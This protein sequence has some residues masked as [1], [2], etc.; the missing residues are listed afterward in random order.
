[1]KYAPILIFTYRRKVDKLIES[2]LKNKLVDEYELFIFSDG[3]KNNLDKEDV[4]EVRKSL[5]TISGFKSIQIY[6]SKTNNGL[7]NSVINGVN[8]IIEEYE[9]V[10]VLE[11]DLVVANDFLDYMNEALDYYKNNQSI[12]SISGY[13]PK[14]DCLESYDKDIFLSLRASS[15]GWATWKDRWGKIDW[16]INDWDVFKTNKSS[17]EKFNLAGDDMFI[18]LK[19]QMLGK[20][21]SWAIRWCYNQFKYKT[22]TIYPTKSKLINNGFDEKGTHN[23]NGYKRWQ[24]KLSNKIVEFEDIDLDENIIECFAKK[25]NLQFK[26]KVGY[27]LKEYGGYKLVKQLSK[28]LKSFR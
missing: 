15:W 9:K 5:E 2:L 14:L 16:D 13:T 24:V 10:I 28:K 23:S 6:E 4:L 8:K 26:T 21:D 20:I 25:Y 22:Y 19:M 11:D 17:I 27:M 1:M 7:A 18:M 12:W 3:Y